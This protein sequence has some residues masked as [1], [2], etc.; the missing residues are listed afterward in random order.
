M[1][2]AG[3]LPI[4]ISVSCQSDTILPRDLQVH[5]LEEAVFLPSY[6]GLWA[7]LIYNRYK[8]N[9]VTWEVTEFQLTWTPATNGDLGD[10][11]EEKSTEISFKTQR[12]PGAL[13]L[14]LENP[15]PLGFAR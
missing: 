5:F 12:D 14:C 13:T 3:G 11:G 4:H 10:E 8:V 15:S 7:V 6:A 1:G 9:C 2:F